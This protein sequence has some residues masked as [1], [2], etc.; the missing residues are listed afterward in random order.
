[1]ALEARRDLHKGCALEAESWEVAKSDMNWNSGKGNLV[2]NTLSGGKGVGRVLTPSQHLVPHCVDEADLDL[3]VDARGKEPN[4]SL[5][6]AGPGAP[7]PSQWAQFGL[8]SFLAFPIGR[9]MAKGLVS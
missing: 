3:A 5:V 1:M 7:G 2:L 4:Y 6:L 9:E 8:Q